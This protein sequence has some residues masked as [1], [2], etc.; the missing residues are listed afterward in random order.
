MNHSAREAMLGRIREALKI[1]APPPGPH[2]GAPPHPAP[3]DGEFRPLLPAVGATWEEQCRQFARNAELLKAAFKVVPHAAAARAEV[4]RIVREEQWQRLAT[5]D[6][7]LLREVGLDFGPTLLFTDRP[8]D[9]AEL[10]KCEGAVTTCEALIAQTGSVLVTSRGCGGRA[11]SILPPHH[12]V[13]AQREQLLPDLLAAFTLLRQKYGAHYPSMISF[14]TGPSRTGDI[15]RILVLGA[16][17]PKR[18]TILL[19]EGK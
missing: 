9:K 15:E 7:P 17:G 13:I 3:R 16:H 6:H 19:L 2:A 12:V 10:E 8:Y 14:I 5:Y 4:E 18:L 1:K 11:I